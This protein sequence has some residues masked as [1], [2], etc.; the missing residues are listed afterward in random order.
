MHK[1]YSMSPLRPLGEGEQP[2]K[3]EKRNRVFKILAKQKSFFV[4]APTVELKDHWM[5]AIQEAAR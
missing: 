1:T 5:K 4:R 2:G 3:K